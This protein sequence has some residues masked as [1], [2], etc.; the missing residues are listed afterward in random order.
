[1][2]DGF[3]VMELPFPQCGLGKV[4]GTLFCLMKY[5]SFTPWMGP[6]GTWIV[7]L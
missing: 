7:D 6:P 2:G 5:S 4:M 3:L 1:M